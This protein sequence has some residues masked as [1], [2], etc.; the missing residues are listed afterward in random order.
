MAIA[1]GNVGTVTKST[2]N[3]STTITTAWDSGSG[4]DR[5]LLVNVAYEDGGDASEANRKRIDWITYNGVDLTLAGA[6]YQ[7]ANANREQHETWYLLDPD[8]GSNNLVV[9]FLNASVDGVVIIAAKVY[10]GVA[11]I[12]AVAQNILAS[13]SAAE[14]VTAT[15]LTFTAATSR[16]HIGLAL[17]TAGM[18]P[19]DSVSG[20]T[21]DHED[22]QGTADGGSAIALGYYDTDAASAKTFTWSPGASTSGSRYWGF[23]AVEL[24][25][26]VSGSIT[27]DSPTYLASDPGT[28]RYITVTRGGD[29]PSTPTA[30]IVGV[31]PNLTRISTVG[32]VAVFTV[33]STSLFEFGQDYAAIRWKTNLTLRVTD[34][35]GD[36]DATIQ[37]YPPIE[38]HFD[39]LAGGAFDY[40]PTSPNASANGDDCYVDRITGDGEGLPIIAGYQ[41]ATVPTQVKFRVYDVSASTWLTAID[42]TFDIASASSDGEL[43]DGFADVDGTDIDD[44]TP[45]TQIINRMWVIDRDVSTASAPTANSVEIQSN[46]LKITAANAG[47][48]YDT[49]DTDA[50]ITVYWLPTGDDNGFSIHA[51]RLDDTAHIHAFIREDGT[52]T[53]NQR[54]NSVNVGLEG[55]TS[56]DYG[57]F[58]LELAAINLK[59]T[60]SQVQLLVNDVVVLDAQSNVAADSSATLIGIFAG[61]ASRIT[62]GVRI[63]SMNA[64][65]GF[66]PTVR[67]LS[68]G[69]VVT[70]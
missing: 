46:K 12:G 18:S 50:D 14:T 8:T 34:S 58:P 39:T 2:S 47:C 13:N 49:G 32:D 40:A 44:H 60:G 19:I 17:S 31:T 28:N 36:M 27:T 55:T 64:Y 30:K 65:S 41:G 52:L 37:I 23:V 42:H 4:S 10:T 56:V 57:Q 15:A 33:P 26:A 59:V 70:F 43:Y 69:A 66:D 61:G 67:T 24:I 45:D 68:F 6:T 22:E 7:A 1:N 48:S 35:S 63:N 25:P 9:Q 16:A 20:W 21:V 62:N 53:I 29:F 3:T 51:R 54:V 5:I 38:D 11:S